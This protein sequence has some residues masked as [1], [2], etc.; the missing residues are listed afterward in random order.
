GVEA[1]TTGQIQIPHRPSFVEAAL[2]YVALGWHCFPL[3][4]RSKK[5]LAGSRGLLDA[6]TDAN[7]IERWWAATPH[8]NVA[9]ATGPSGL[10]VLDRD[11]PQ[12]A[13]ELHG[14]VR[15]HGPLPRTLVSR[16]ANGLHLVYR[17]DGVRSTARGNLHVRGL[18]GYIVTPPSVHASGHV[19]H[20]V[21]PLAP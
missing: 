16:T 10:T 6:T 7:Q 4:P 20:W 21:D 13:A 19:Y 9:I 3:S 2:K 15:L 11:G 8:A 17:G 18:G 14:L 5:P 12:G 1:V